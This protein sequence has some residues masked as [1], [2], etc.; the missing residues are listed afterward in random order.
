MCCREKRMYNMTREKGAADFNR[1]T[2]EGFPE[3]VPF[4]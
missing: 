4:E 3:K 2:K 1:M